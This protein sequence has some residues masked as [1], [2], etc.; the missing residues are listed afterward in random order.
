MPS[1]HRRPSPDQALSAEVAGKVVHAR[2]HGSGGKP[3]SSGPA[4]GRTI[5]SHEFYITSPPS[6]SSE[7]IGG[8]TSVSNAYSYQPRSAVVSPGVFGPSTGCAK[9]KIETLPI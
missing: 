5:A 9:H 7:E 8:N 6:A 2:A 4:P 3:A 1:P